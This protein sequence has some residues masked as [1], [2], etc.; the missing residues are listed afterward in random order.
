[1]AN[2]KDTGIYPVREGTNPFNDNIYL[3]END[4]EW[5]IENHATDT[6]SEGVKTE[7]EGNQLFETAIAN[8]QF[9]ER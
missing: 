7:A 5:W 6:I 1:M 9:S 3:F 2:D 8:A 4:G